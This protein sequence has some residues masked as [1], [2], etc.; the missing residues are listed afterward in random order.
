MITRLVRIRRVEGQCIEFVVTHDR[1]SRP[2]IDHRP[3]DLQCFPNLGSTVDEVAEED[4]P[5]LWVLVDALLLGV[6]ELPQEPLEGVSVAVDVTDEVV[7]DFS[8]SNP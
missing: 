7:H 1:Q 6:A 8:L 2:G 4:H 3:D 5:S